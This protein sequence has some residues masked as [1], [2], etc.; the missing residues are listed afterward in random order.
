MRLCG[1][2]GVDVHAIG[3]SYMVKDTVWAQARMPKYLGFLCI[4][5]LENRLGFELSLSDFTDAPINT[6]IL[7]HN[8]ARLIGRLGGSLGSRSADIERY[9]DRFL[10]G[11]KSK[12]GKQC[13]SQ[14]D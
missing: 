8:S 13:V 11:I 5:C 2:C 1:D 6:P 10:Q 12:G 4:G 14:A 3:E 7:G 9:K